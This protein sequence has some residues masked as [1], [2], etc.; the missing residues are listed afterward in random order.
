MKSLSSIRQG[1]GQPGSGAA[2][3][4]TLDGRR[5]AQPKSAFGSPL[6]SVVTVE[7]VGNILGRYTV[8]RVCHLDYQTGWAY[9]S[10]EVNSSTGR[11]VCEGVGNEVADRALE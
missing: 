10:A 2:S 1:K 4:K 8:A 7:Q 6:R 9:P 3:W 11:G 5:A